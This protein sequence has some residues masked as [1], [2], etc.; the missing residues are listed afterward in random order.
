[1]TETHLR[2]E[3]DPDGVGRIVLDRP[4]A[5]NALTIA[6]R[7]GIIEAVRS[8]RS[9]PKVRAVLITGDAGIGKSAIVAE[10]I[11]T[12]PGNRVLAYHCCQWDRARDTLDAILPATRRAGWAY[13]ARVRA[14]PGA[15]EN[16]ARAARARGCRW[17]R[18]A[19]VH[20]SR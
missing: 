14:A 1:M 6:M 16:R 8:F 7:D 20:R 5:K 11:Y 13:R 15:L 12:N 3:R 9:D 18:R 10:L 17:R 19:H 4:D 2:V